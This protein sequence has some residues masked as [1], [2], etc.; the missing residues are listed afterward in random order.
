MDM[1]TQAAATVCDV[2]VENPRVAVVLS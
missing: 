1:R 2:F